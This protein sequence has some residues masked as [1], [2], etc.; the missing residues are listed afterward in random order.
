MSD[1]KILLGRLAAGDLFHAGTPKGVSLICLAVSTTESTI[2][3][4]RVTTQEYF[5]FDRQT[6]LER[7][8]DEPASRIDSV[9]PLPTDVLNVMLAIDRKYRFVQDSDQG[10]LTGP[11]IKALMYAGAHYSSKPI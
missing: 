6:G 8:G 1:R 10:K 11:E 4:R 9:A 5:E 3:A 7:C 2:R